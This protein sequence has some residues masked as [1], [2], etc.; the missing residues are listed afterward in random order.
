MLCVCAVGFMVNYID[1]RTQLL[2]IY[3]SALQ[4]VAGDRAVNAWLSANPL[5]GEWAVVAIGKAAAAM[6]RGAVQGLGRQLNRGL[7]IT[8][9]G[10]GDPSLDPARFI[11][12]ES[13]HPVPDESSLVA[14]EALLDFLD[15]LPE[16]L[17]LLFLVSGGAS[18]LVEVLPEGRDQ[19]HLS[20][21]NRW[22]LASGLPIKEMNAIRKRLSR[23]KGGRLAAYLRGRRCVQ[24]MI[25]DVPGDEPAVIGSGMLLPSTLEP[26]SLEG[27]IPSFLHDLLRM[28][29]PEP[30][31]DDPVFRMIESH[32]IADNEKARRAAEAKAVA[33]GIAVHD[34]YGHFQGEVV[35]LAGRFCRE[36]LD[37]K[38][39][40]TL[41][42]GESSVR[43][44]ANPGRGGRNQHLA[45]A[46]ARHLAGRRNVLLL[47]AGTD[48]SDGP[49]EDAGAVVDGET[50]LRG[51]REGMSAAEALSRFDSGSFLE[52]S[53][54]LIETGPTG[55][56][57][58]DLVIGWRWG[59]VE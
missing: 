57:V 2:Q 10:H 12:L 17:P 47:A 23:I 48:G 22:L 26:S 3:R 4:A 59:G 43:L 11:Q 35:E 51:E 39:G 13:A 38:P 29:L 16:G 31:A 42:G 46:A 30:Q 7:V 53:G 49:T 54:D 40:I 15:D 9:Y 20:E 18:A 24:L 25:S 58:M 5:E 56:N 52:L 41:W 34:H 37:G 32:I 27:E 8:K 19:A 6:A 50:V 33:L 21:L 1:R 14:G 28:A 36:L 45:L 44:P 55:T